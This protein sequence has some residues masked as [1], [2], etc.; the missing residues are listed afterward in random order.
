[1][2][3]ATPRRDVEAAGPIA[4]WRDGRITAPGGRVLGDRALLSA[5]RERR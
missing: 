1:M 2:K 5:L 4:A 3:I